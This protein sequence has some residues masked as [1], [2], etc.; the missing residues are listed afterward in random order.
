MK[1]HKH[2]VDSTCDALRNIFEDGFYADKVIERQF[3]THPKWGGRDRKFVAEAVYE[4]VRHWRRLLE[5]LDLWDESALSPNDYAHILW[6]WLALRSEIN[7]KENEPPLQGIEPLE[8][9]ELKTAWREA[10]LMRATRFSL[11]DWLDQLGFQELKDDWEPCLEFLQTRAQVVLRAN[12]LKT[13]SADLQKKLLEE[14]I[15]TFQASHPSFPHLEETLTLKAR[16]NVFATQAFKT[17]LFEV[18][19]AGSQMIAPFLNPSPG[20]KI[21]D[22]CAGAGGKTL[23]LAALMKNKGRIWAMDVEERKLEEL[24]KRSSRA[25]VDII[26]TRLIDSSKVVKRLEG[27]ADALLLDVPCSGLGVL[28]RNPDTK[29]KLRSEDIE[30]VKKIQSEILDRYP[31][32]V[33][34]G[35]RMVY[36]TCS[37]LPSENS[38]Q[39]LN[40]L[41]SHPE[42]MLEEEKTLLPHLSETDGFYMARL[43]KKQ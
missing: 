15:E 32:M 12:T 14:S 13:T 20:E 41:S 9:K 11:P 18:Q 39:I 36:A 26:E 22:A 35:G 17:G 38:K 6:A 25:G 3:K 33:K 43:K 2:L 10:G 24:R 27:Q 8:L 21:V 40:F 29:W 30:H 28:R 7:P 1:I 16:K 37:V 34:P 31:L 4:V 19:D 23:H 5:T 42:W